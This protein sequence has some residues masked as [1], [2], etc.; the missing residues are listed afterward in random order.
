MRTALALRGYRCHQTLCK[1]FFPFFVNWDIAN[2]K[3]EMETQRRKLVP[4]V[5]IKCIIFGFVYGM[6]TFLILN[7]YFHNAQVFTIQQILSF[8]VLLIQLPLSIG[9][10]AGVWL[11]QKELVSVVN[12]FL[13]QDKLYKSKLKL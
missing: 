9:C 12:W 4:I 1:L 6:A 7:S 3:W 11:F 10:D 13:E 8:A 2:R 5:T